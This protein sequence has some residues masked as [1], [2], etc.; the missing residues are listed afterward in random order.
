VFRF[1]RVT[2]FLIAAASPLAAQTPAS[3]LADSVLLL[4]HAGQYDHAGGVARRGFA[5]NPSP[6]ELCA[7]H[8]GAAYALT[9]VGVYASAADQLEMV[10]KDCAQSPVMRQQAAD[11]AQIRRELA[12]PPMPKTGMD[13]SAIDQFWKVADQLVQDREPSDADWHAMLGTVGY[14]LSMKVVPTTR[15][16]LEIALRPSRRAEFDSL[17][18]LQT[19]QALRLKHLALAF[20]HRAQ[21]AKLRDSLTRSLPIRDAIA[22]SAKYLP[23]HATEGIDPPVVAFAI[24][25][26]DAYSLGPEG[27]VVDLDHMLDNP[28]TPLLAHEF[29]HSFLSRLSKVD[30]ATGDTPDASLLN[31]LFGLRN[32]GIADLVDKPYPLSYPGNAMMT[33]YATRYNEAYARTPAVLHSIDSLLAI[34]ADDST[35]MRRVG[36]QIANLLPSNGHYN[37][38]YV[39]REIYETFGIDSL[40]PGVAN[41]FALL[42]TYSAAEVKHGRPAPFSAKAVGVLDAVE[43]KYLK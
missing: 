33:M 18:K 40:Y 6:D 12:L 21:I 19:D 24:F 35:Q 7:L 43:R 15:S 10:D 9:K 38:S 14:R 3:V 16:D 27:V 28:L 5:A 29:H 13:F 26:D 22:G 42:R 41:P 2:L 17:T 23:P 4:N 20:T 25:R 8:V 11:I 30:R 31:A 37:G 39:A 32:E 34:V 1:V 36:R